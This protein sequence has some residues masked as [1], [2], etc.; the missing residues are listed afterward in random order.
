MMVKP[1]EFRFNVGI[2]VRR[3][4][5][6]VQMEPV[7]EV[8]VVQWKFIRKIEAHLEDLRDEETQHEPT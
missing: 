1:A 4:E 3:E 2:L 8:L 7:P 6:E 5:E